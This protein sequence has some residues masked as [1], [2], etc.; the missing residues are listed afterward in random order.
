LKISID[1]LWIIINITVGN[2][3]P[4]TEADTKN[5]NFATKNLKN[6]AIDLF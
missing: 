2:A 1:K 5:L 6:G 4:I 3:A